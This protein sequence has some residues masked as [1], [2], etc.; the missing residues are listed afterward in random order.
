MKRQMLLP[1][2]VALAL[3][4]AGVGCSAVTPRPDLLGQPAPPSAATRTIAITPATRWVNVTSGDTVNFVVDG[5]AFAWS[6][7]VAPT[8]ATFDLN[9]VAPP[10]VLGRE[11]RVYVAPDPRY[12]I[13]TE[14]NDDVPY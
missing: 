11:L 1:S 6:F 5:K 2:I 14:W 13:R 7:M 10:G 3:L 8:V 9:Q 12:Y 4:S